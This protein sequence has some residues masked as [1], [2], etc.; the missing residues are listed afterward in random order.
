M[1]VFD[2][3]DLTAIGERGINLSG[4]QKQRINLARM[5]YFNADVL[6]MD[7]PLSAVDAHVGK[8]LF[9]KCIK[10]ALGAKTRILV[11]HQLQFLPKVDHIIVMNQGI[12]YYY[13]GKISEQ[14]T[15][16]TLMKSNG[17]FS[18]LLTDHGGFNAEEVGNLVDNKMETVLTSSEGLDDDNHLSRINKMLNEKHEVSA[19]KLMEDEERASGQVSSNVW[20]SYMYASGGIWFLVGLILLFAISQCVSIGTNF[21]LVI[22]SNQSIPSFSQ[23]RCF[24]RLIIATSQ[25]I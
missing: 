18:S 22:W 16:A 6:L 12:F 9:E 1:E 21:W 11:T 3:G 2:D 20:K 24:Y 23:N 19:R 8:Y 25:C 5:V 17:A 7:D 4:G 10:G 13:E 14:G 15:F